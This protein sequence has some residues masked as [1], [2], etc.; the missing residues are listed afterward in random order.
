M[1]EKQQDNFIWQ[2]EQFADIRILRYKINGFESLQINQKLLLW[3]LYNA[4]LA[5][6]DIIFDQNYKFN[7]IIRKTLEAIIIHYRG[8]RNCDDWKALLVYMKRIWFSNG[9]HHHYSMEKFL[10]EFSED[11]FREV[12]HDLHDDQLPIHALQT[13]SE[14]LEQIVPLM[15][16]PSI[17]PKRVNQ[18]KGTD[19]VEN[20]ACNFY[21]GVS[22]AEA[23]SF[24]AS[25]NNLDDEEPVSTGLNSK[26]IKVNGQIKELVYKAD[27]RYGKAI[28]RIVIW[29]EKSKTY[30]ESEL[31]RQIID[32]LIEF[33]ETGNLRV[34]D[35]Y[36]ILWVK[37]TDSEVD[38]VNGF[39][40]V[41]GDPLGYHGSWQS[42]V[43]I[44][45]EEATRRFSLISELAG[46]CELNSP[47]A[48]EHKRDD[49]QGISYKVIQVIVES[50][51][52]APSS[53]IGVNLPNADWIRSLHGSKS[54]SLG[55]IEHSYEMASRNTGSIEAFYLPEQQERVRNFGP[56]ASQIHTGLHEVIGHGSGKILPGVGTPKETLK[57]YSNTI[58]EA[59]ADLVAL[60]FMLDDKLI[61]TGLI[62]SDEVGKAEYDSFMLNG[63]MRQLVRVEAGKQ[64]EESHMRNRQLIA[65]WA[66][67]KGLSEKIVEKVVLDGKTFFRI[68][69]YPR[70]RYLFG[71]LLH[72]IQ[73]IK[74]EGDYEAARNLV[75]NYGVKVDSVLH[76]EVLERWKMLNIAPFAGF[77]QPQLNTIKTDGKIVDVFVS[78]PDDFTAQM[79]D[80][81][82]YHSFLSAMND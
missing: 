45:D 38:F 58:E 27:G 41:Y 28:R 29:L 14:L 34:F 21:E 51:D 81:G 48:K 15:Y 78:Y 39:I 23:E 36:S 56:L 4:A 67:E 72:E 44:R 65:M 7:L 68:N 9:I 40:E 71:M 31:Q 32:K 49:A 76:Q 22:Q 66:Y 60:Y 55:N 3:Y 25:I 11:F 46:W 79:M 10:P 8:D 52:N 62:D 50:G 53:P 70:L 13:A 37:D 18:E 64:L 82:R 77:I 12:Y 1:A 2:T 42:V 43:S 6:R 20:S 73:R 75:E 30:A 57:S 16:D 17:A 61:E 59:R 69:D 5:G 26:L 47:I 80:Y 33:Y 35:E 54:V 19:L 63:M 74:S 24:Y